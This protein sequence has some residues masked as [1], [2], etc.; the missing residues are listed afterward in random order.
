MPP[1]RC[2]VT[3][4]GKSFIVTVSAPKAPCSATHASVNTG[5]A[6]LRGRRRA[7]GARA[8]D[9]SQDTTASTRISTPTP[10]AR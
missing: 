1:A 7:W 5:Q 9:P 3:I 6:A 2:S 4:A 8:R 10:V